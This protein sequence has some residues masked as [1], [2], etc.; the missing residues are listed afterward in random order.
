MDESVGQ[1]DVDE[2]FI[3]KYSNSPFIRMR[4]VPPELKWV[5]GSNYCDINTKATK[6]KIIISS[7]IDNLIKGASGQ[8]IQNMNI[9]Y[10]W[11]EQLGL[12]INTE[13]FQ[14]A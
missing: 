7:A 8:A 12:K 4:K 5:T 9:L 6:N 2:I 3:N 13:E 1:K 14:N 11:N 10:G